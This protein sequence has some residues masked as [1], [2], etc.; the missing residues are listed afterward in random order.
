MSPFKKY[1][2]AYYELIEETIA[3]NLVLHGSC[4]AVMH[5]T[6]RMGCTIVFRDGT[7]MKVIVSIGGFTMTTS[8]GQHTVALERIQQSK[9]NWRKMIATD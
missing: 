2:D 6:H 8:S 3:S 7:E 5:D 9:I 4:I 1:L